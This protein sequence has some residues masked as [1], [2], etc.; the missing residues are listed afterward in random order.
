MKTPCPFL[1]RTSR[2]PPRGSVVRAMPIYWNP[3]HMNEVAKRCPTHVANSKNEHPSQVRHLLTSEHREARHME[4]PLT[5]RLSVIIPHE[6]PQVGSLWVTSLFQFMCYSSCHGGYNRRPLHVIFTLEHDNQVL[7]RQ[8]IK[9]RLCACPGRDWDNEA[10]P[11]GKKKRNSNVTSFTTD[12]SE[13]LEQLES[14]SKAKP[15]IIVSQNR[16]RKIGSSTFNSSSS[17]NVSNFM[18]ETLIS[19]SN[20]EYVDEI[21]QRMNPDDDLSSSKKNFMCSNETDVYTLRVVGRLNFEIL[22]KL[23]DSLH[24]VSRLPVDVLDKYAFVD[25]SEN[26]SE[27]LSVETKPKAQCKPKIKMDPT[28][29][30]NIHSNNATSNN[31]QQQQCSQQQQNCFQETSNKFQ[32]RHQIVIQQ[33]AASD[34]SDGKLLNDYSIQC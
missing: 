16:K 31:Q 24:V 7:G 19:N 4:D 23:R 30:L 17:S 21:A 9:V 18:L 11:R 12:K 13:K 32:M 10:N 34:Q 14:N 15:V 28:Q 27:S 8:V 20:E 22:R 25:G 6:E 2:T 33:L 26:D 1:F 29:S 3:E 5:K